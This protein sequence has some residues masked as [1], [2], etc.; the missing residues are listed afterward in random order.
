MKKI[1]SLGRS[2]S[3]GEQQKISGGA[4]VCVCANG[5]A[6]ICVGWQTFCQNDAIL[7]CAHNGD[8]AMCGNQDSLT[9]A[10]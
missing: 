10:P 7:Y 8:G 2:L 6:W 9:P 1:Q 4:L 3:K 5:A